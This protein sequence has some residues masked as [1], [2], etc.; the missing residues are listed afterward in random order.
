MQKNKKQKNKQKKYKTKKVAKKVKKIEKIEIPEKI[1]KEEKEIYLGKI[2]HYYDKIKVI[3]LKLENSLSVGDK[4]RIVGGEK[5]DFTQ[6]VNSMEISHQKIN[7]AKKGQEIG[8]KVKEKAKE[9]YKVYKI[10]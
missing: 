3:A 1:K 6:K 10:I 4:I 2:N 9:G 7:V 5:T 8:I